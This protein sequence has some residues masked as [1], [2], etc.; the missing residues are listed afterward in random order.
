MAVGAMSGEA[1]VAIVLSIRSK[2]D[3]KKSRIVKTPGLEVI[4]TRGSSCS[5]LSPKRRCFLVKRDA[6]P[7]RLRNMSGSS[8]WRSMV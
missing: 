5:T 8:W 1:G 2:E 7:R 4:K 3:A 6:N